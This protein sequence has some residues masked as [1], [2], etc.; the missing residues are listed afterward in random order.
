MS[1][2]LSLGNNLTTNGVFKPA[3]V[4]NTSVNNVTDFASVPAGG[5]LFLLSTQ[6]ASASASIEFTSGIDSTY[7]SYIFK[8]INCHPASD[9]RLF[10]F[11]GSTDGGSTYAV[12]KTT[13]NFKATHDEA[14]TSTNLTYDT[15]NDLA[16]STADQRLGAKFGIDNDQSM[17]ATMYLFSPSST[18]YVK[19]FIATSQNYTNNDLSQSYFVAGYMNTTSS[20]NAIKFVMDTGNIDA[21]TIRMYGIQS[22]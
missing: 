18:T 6:T 16:Q 10:Q 5:A 19:H 2:A 22:S 14:D 9:N 20:V 7:D 21:G 8:I 4:N 3:A 15:G 17:C 13:T 12:T 11:N 1:I